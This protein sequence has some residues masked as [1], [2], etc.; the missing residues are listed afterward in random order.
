M[1]IISIVATLLISAVIF[2]PL[3]INIRKK[4]AESK[5]ESAE[6]EANFR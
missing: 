4:T 3:G 5:I 1:Q 2:I 6:K